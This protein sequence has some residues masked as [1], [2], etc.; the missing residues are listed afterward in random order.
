MIAYGDF[1]RQIPIRGICFT[2]CRFSNADSDFLFTTGT[3]QCSIGN[4]F[5]LFLL[6]RRWRAD[7]SETRKIL[8]FDLCRGAVLAPDGVINFLAMNADLFG[9][10]DAE[11]DLV[12]TNIDDGH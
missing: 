6:A 4:L 3:R 12:A 1:V 11:T 10:I 5:L 9:G 8:G 7:L 2:Y